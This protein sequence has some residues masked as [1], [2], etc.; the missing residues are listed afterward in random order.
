VDGLRDQLS[1]I[2]KQQFDDRWEQ[3]IY[4]SFGDARSAAHLR[5][6][7]LALDLSRAQAA[8]PKGKLATLSPELAAAYAGR[9]QKTLTRD[10]NALE[11]MGFSCASAPAIGQGAS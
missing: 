11:T 4:E 9:T 2:K 6:R 5:Q 10:V 8:V 3:Y 1:L 7:Q